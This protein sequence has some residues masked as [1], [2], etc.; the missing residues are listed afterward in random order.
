MIRQL[1]DRRDAENPRHN[2]TRERDCEP[3][4]VEEILPGILD[5]GYNPD[6]ADYY[7]LEDLRP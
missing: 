4:P 3:H 2:A 7:D 6:P 5:D 1:R